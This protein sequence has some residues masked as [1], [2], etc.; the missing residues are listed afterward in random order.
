MTTGMRTN[1][2]IR[3]VAKWKNLSHNA[4]MAWIG[5]IGLVLGFILG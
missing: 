5:G 1:L 3:L 4:Q 2:W